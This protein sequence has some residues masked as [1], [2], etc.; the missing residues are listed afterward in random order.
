MRPIDPNSKIQRLLT[1]AHGRPGRWFV[2]DVKPYPATDRR[3]ATCAWERRYIAEPGIGTV[4]WVRYVK[5]VPLEELL[6]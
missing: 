1:R 4:T 5:G 3:L 6:G 2:F